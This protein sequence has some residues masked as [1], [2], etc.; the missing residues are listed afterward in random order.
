MNINEI[1]TMSP[2]ALS[3]I[4]ALELKKLSASVSAQE[5]GLKATKSKLGEALSIRYGEKVKTLR[6]LQGQKTG[7]VS[8]V[9]DELPIKAEIGKKVSWDSEKLGGILPH[10][11]QEE[12]DALEIKVEIKI[13]EKAYEEAP[14][15]IKTALDAARTVTF[16][17]EKISLK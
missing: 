12:R 13:P 9:F 1:A 3:Q 11:S 6:E 7:T 14:S 4:P 2:E 5:K 16:S 17:D 15:Q 10:F 8:G